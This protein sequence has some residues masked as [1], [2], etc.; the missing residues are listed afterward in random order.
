MQ[1]KYTYY[2]KALALALLLPCL[3]GCN[4]GGGG[5]SSGSLSSFVFGSGN[6]FGGG[7]D[8]SS[9]PLV[10][11]NSLSGTDTTTTV[12]TDETETPTTSS[13][14]T[15]ETGTTSTFSEETTD[16]ET[17]EPDLQLARIHNPEPAT[18]LLLGSG[19]TA[20]ALARRRKYNQK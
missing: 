12:Q 13:E 18:M 5:S 7:D 3:Y 9:L 6:A 11:L 4:S 2:L 14:E 15:G 20:M 8:M 16:A 1:R 17:T 10:V 19:M